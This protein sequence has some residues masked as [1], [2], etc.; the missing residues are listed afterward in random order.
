MEYLKYESQ[1]EHNVKIKV[2]PD[3]TRKSTCCNKPI[4]KE[5]GYVPVLD[6]NCT[7]EKRTYTTDN[8]SRSDSVKRAKD[9]VF[10]IA[11]LNEFKY[12]VTLTLDMEKIESRYDSVLVSEKLQ[13]WLKNM[14]TR[15]GLV[16]LLIPE[17]HRDGAIHMHMLCSGNLSLADTGK[18]TKERKPIYNLKDWKYGFSTVIEITGSSENISKYVVKYITK[19]SEKIF[20]KFYYS[21]GKGLNKEPKIVYADINFEAFSYLKQYVVE[22]A[23]LCFCYPSDDDLKGV[24]ENDL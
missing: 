24:F 8:V 2:Y 12:F 6:P 4:F 5:K 14:V 22:N 1:I 18:K 20:G 3:G 19:D 15:K 23:G 9:K 17:H 13:T 7:Y 16:Y 21:G 10:D 11:K